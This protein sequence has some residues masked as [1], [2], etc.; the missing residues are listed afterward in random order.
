[1]PERLPVRVEDPR[2]ASWVPWLL[3]LVVAALLLRL[4]DLGERS[5]AH[6]E[7]FSPGLDMPEWVRFPPP[8]HDLDA[9]L[10]GTLIDGHPPTYFV[11]LLPWTKLFGSSL[12][13]LRFPSALLGAAAVALV[14][15]IARREGSRRVALF[16]ACLLALHGHHV[17]WSQQARMYV[18]V[19]TLALLSTWFMLRLREHGRRGDLWA[20][21]A[22]TGLALSTQMYAWPLVFA[23]SIG[24]LLLDIR[25]RRSPTVARAQV[26]TVIACL[27]VVQLSV[28][29]NPPTRWHGGANE[30]WQLGYLFHSSTPFF[31]G[32]PSWV[33]DGPWLLGLGLGLLALAAFARRDSDL[34][35][36]ALPP[37]QVPQMRQRPAIAITLVSTLL[38]V[39]FALFAPSRTRIDWTPLWAL[40]AAPALIAIAW[41]SLERRLAV[42]TRAPPAWLA[43]IA[44]FD[45]PLSVH[46]AVI[47]AL[48]M[49]LVSLARGVLVPRG[50]IV[51]LPFLSVAI[52]HGIAACFRVRI[53]GYVVLMLVVGLHLASLR[54]F[55]AAQNSPRDYAGLAQ[56]LT[57][58]LRSSDVIVVRNNFSSPPLLY[59]LREVQAQCIPYEPAWM[60]SV[61]DDSR[62]W[63]I[64]F[65][66]E[67]P[68]SEPPVVLDGRDRTRS[69]DVP[70]ARAVLWES[71]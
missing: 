34:A 56:Q 25:E 61:N 69:I 63:M 58:Q 46:L 11:A 2:P 5:L 19:A 44:A 52:A 10:R 57:A 27:W 66:G 41:A 64:E 42:L 49:V 59:Y 9:V 22:T 1:M 13:S 3:L 38:L 36:N 23:Q 26:Y 70:G 32:R 7:N 12:S 65:A 17:Y 29:Q 62:V 39:S 47:P 35:Y 51:F 16:A 53:V 45:V 30:Y 4:D 60:E 28:Y 55:R 68:R 50:T 48:L 54:Y 33:F 37:E 6:P 14:F 24:A 18:P 31:H 43:R 40:C 67:T 71:R 15:L 8:R 21:V 20:F